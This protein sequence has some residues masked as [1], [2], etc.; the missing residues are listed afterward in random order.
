M[1]RNLSTF[2]IASKVIH[3]GGDGLRTH[4]PLQSLWYFKLF[5]M[6]GRRYLVHNT[7][8]TLHAIR[9]PCG[10]FNVLIRKLWIWL[11]NVS[12]SSS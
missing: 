10:V 1:L 6:K 3:S 9:A 4:L 7:G 2:E 5:L 12:S 8:S 11:E